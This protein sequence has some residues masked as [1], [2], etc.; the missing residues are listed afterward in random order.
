MIAEVC[1]LSAVGS[2]L[3]LTYKERAISV[4]TFVAMKNEIKARGFY[5]DPTAESKLR[6]RWSFRPKSVIADTDSEVLRSIKLA[7]IAAYSRAAKP[8]KIASR[9]WYALLVV[10]IALLLFR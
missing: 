5:L 7:H 2:R 4:R 3:F 1:A 9:I 10:A 8:W 6:W